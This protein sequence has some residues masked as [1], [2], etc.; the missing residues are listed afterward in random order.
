MFIDNEAVITVAATDFDLG[1]VRPGP[2]EPIKMSVINDS[3]TAGTYTGPIGAL[4]MAVTHGDDA[5]G[6]TALMTVAVIAGEETH[7]E[8]PKNT[9]RYIQV[10]VLPANAVV[11]VRMSGGQTNL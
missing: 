11:A 3:A 9:K 5:G 6:E 1:S 8:L 2:G 4:S 7:F 10:A